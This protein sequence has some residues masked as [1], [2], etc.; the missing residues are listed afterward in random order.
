MRIDGKTLGAGAGV[1]IIAFLIGALLSPFKVCSTDGNPVGFHM[2]G[3]I[4]L[5]QTA[6]LSSCSKTQCY[7]QID[8][9][10]DPAVAPNATPTPCAS[11]TSCFSFSNVP[12]APLQSTS[13]AIDYGHPGDPKTYTD[14]LYGVV[15]GSLNGPSRSAPSPRPTPRH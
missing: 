7:F 9:T 3:Y 10:F 14:Y 8:M 1:A 12:P 15:Q 2:G 11:R 5:D 6:N 4:K 13:V